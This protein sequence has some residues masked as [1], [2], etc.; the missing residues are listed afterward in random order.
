MTG[1]EVDRNELSRKLAT[2]RMK[3]PTGNYNNIAF[4]SKY[5]YVTKNNNKEKISHTWKER[6]ETVRNLATGFLLYAN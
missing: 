4:L 5:D 3:Q 6:K 2:P 1:R